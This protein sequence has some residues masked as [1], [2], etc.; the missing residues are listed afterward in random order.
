MASTPV[1]ATTV[2][3]RM[4]PDLQHALIGAAESPPARRDWWS[5]SIAKHGVPA[6]DALAEWLSD[7]DLR[8]FALRTI[9]LA[10]EHGGQV[11]LG[12][13]QSVLAG[14]D[15][16]QMSRD[17]LAT[18]WRAQGRI[19]ALAKHRPI[20][21]P[22][23]GPI[24]DLVAGRLYRRTA[25]HAAGLGGN[26]QKGISYPANGDHATLF[27]TGQGRDVYGYEDRWDG[28]EFVYYGEWSGSGDMTFTG[29]NQAI[30]DRSPNLYLLVGQGKGIY[31]FEGRFEY[32]GH[33]FQRA[34]REGKE[35]RAIVFRLR[36]VSERVDL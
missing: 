1:A 5:E 3:T 36:K 22:A 6:I 13:A 4:A 21:P 11:A 35:A 24:G 10:A 30:I 16:R 23:G 25:L 28:D 12:A 15:T 19:D 2:T 18:F 27:P 29:G 7:D 9:V 8:P 17:E 33:T 32:S 20:G 34:V 31:L 14:F 26:R